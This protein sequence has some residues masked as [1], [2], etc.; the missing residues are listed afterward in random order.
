MANENTKDGKIAGNQDKIAVKDREVATEAMSP[1]PRPDQGALAD[2]LGPRPDQGALGKEELMGPRPDQ[3]ALESVVGPR[4]DQG[5]LEV[6]GPRPDQGGLESAAGPRPDQGALGLEALLGPRPDQSGLESMAGPRPD[7]GAL[8]AMA[9]PRPDQGALLGKVRAARIQ[10]TGAP[11]AWQGEDPIAG[12][13]EALEARLDAV[14]Q[15]IKAADLRR[16]EGLADKLDALVGMLE[17][18]S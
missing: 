14:A 3:G 18:R 16:L 2:V 10:S 7:Q 4:P 9:G 12:R 15:R 11:E 5:S 1:G 6:L 8:E 17:R 13:I